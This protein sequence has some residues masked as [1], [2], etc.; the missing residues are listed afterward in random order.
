MKQ[1][2]QM[3]MCPLNHSLNILCYP[4][5]LTLETKVSIKVAAPDT[6]L[7][8]SLSKTVERWQ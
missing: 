3:K 2:K 1:Q 8:L 5:T 7:T 6:T 4:L